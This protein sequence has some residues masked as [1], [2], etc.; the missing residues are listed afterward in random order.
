MLIISATWA[1][2]ATAVLASAS[3]PV[4]EHWNP[5]FEQHAL[6]PYSGTR[7]PD[8]HYDHLMPTVL[9]PIKEKQRHHPFTPAT[10][11]RVYFSGSKS[12]KDEER[13][14]V[15]FRVPRDG[16][17]G[18]YC[19]LGFFYD[20]GYPRGGDEQDGVDAG[21]RG[22]SWMYAYRLRQEIFIGKTTYH[23]RPKRVSIVADFLIKVPPEGG[24]A[25]VSGGKM[26]CFP[27][28]IITFEIV[29]E[30]KVGMVDVRWNQQ[31]KEGNKYLVESGIG[32]RLGNSWLFQAEMY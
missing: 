29:P 20:R 22:Q 25:L 10:F 6:E 32:L 30:T 2:L 16:S 5:G 24:H 23:G 1:I 4:V 31:A 8:E 17:L 11:G 3:S 12:T 27:G 19:Y 21:V 26:E 7:P 18:K 13:M 14:L 15:S 28:E 9:A